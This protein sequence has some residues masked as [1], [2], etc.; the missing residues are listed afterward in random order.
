MMKKLVKLFI[1]LTL[2]FAIVPT[3]SWNV[4]ATN[5]SAEPVITQDEQ[6]EVTE[7]QLP[8]EVVI[9]SATPEVEAT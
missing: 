4:F 2:I 1:T 3:E 5:S 6:K 9:P 7:T 8:E